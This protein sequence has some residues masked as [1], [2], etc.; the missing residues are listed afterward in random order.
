MKEGER[1]KRIWMTDRTWIEVIFL[2]STASWDLC[3]E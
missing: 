1:R 2:A 3:D